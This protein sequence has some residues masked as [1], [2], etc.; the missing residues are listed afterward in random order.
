MRILW[1]CNV[2]I[3]QVCEIIGVPC[4]VFGGWLNQLSEIVD[5]NNDITLGICA[6]SNGENDQNAVKWGNDSLFWGFSSRKPLIQYDEELTEKFRGII[7]QFEPDI[8][9]IFGTEYAYSLSMIRAFGKP[10]R[11]VVHIQGLTS[12]YA[13]H[14]HANL[15]AEVTNRR[16]L[17]DIYCK[18]SIK[19]EKRSFEKRGK[20]EIEV[21]KNANNIMGR[22]EWDKACT[23]SINLKA[24]YFYVQELIRKVFYN[25]EWNYDECEKHSIF[26]SQ[27]NY[28]IKGFHIV[29]QILIE[30]K[31]IYPDVKLYVAGENNY[32][33]D[34]YWSKL[35]KGSYAKYIIDIIE[36]N[37]LKQHIVF[38]GKLDEEKMKNTYLRSNVFLLASSIENSPNSIGE[39]MLLGVP[40]VSAFVGGVQS[41]IE[42]NVNGFLCQCDAPYMMAY[43]ISRIFDS[44]ETGMYLSKNEREKARAM[45]SREV[46]EKDLLETYKQIMKE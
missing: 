32:E 12:I 37:N 36:K 34:T 19:K 41:L 23:C 4:N 33:A 39:A 24:K 29:L 21:L 27:A 10:N 20:Y 15:P 13:K 16:T 44:K 8:V 18:T 6:P 31:K 38:L 42:H 17:Y 28:P 22:T 40:I 30:L 46:I 2:I 25:G 26:I 9:H 11:T 7:E 3:P 5:K 45:Y 14:Y 43:Y 1:L 35:K